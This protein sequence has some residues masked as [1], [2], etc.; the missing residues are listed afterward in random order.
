MTADPAKTM[1]TGTH[2]FYQGNREAGLHRGVP[3][4]PGYKAPINAGFCLR[5]EFNH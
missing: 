4:E 1:W 2:K 3:P 5:R